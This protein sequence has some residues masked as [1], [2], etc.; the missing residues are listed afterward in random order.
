MAERTVEG[1]KH[2]P[3]K[4]QSWP[5]AKDLCQVCEQ[6]MTHSIHWASVPEEDQ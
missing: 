2:R 5:R 6:P 4:G 3:H 1:M